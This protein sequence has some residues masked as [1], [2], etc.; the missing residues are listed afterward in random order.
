ML[1]QGIYHLAVPFSYC[2]ENAVP[3]CLRA[4]PP[5]L[6]TCRKS[7]QASVL[8]DR[9]RN[10]FCT[11]S[12]FSILCWVNLT[13]QNLGKVTMHQQRHSFPEEVLLICRKQYHLTVQNINVTRK[14]NKNTP[15]KQKNKPE[16]SKVHVTF[17]LLQ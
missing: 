3:P 7:S 10:F 13:G 6:V 2:T 4:S 17:C 15:N 11:K 14:N 1:I 5:H 12:G 8:S 16:K 9:A